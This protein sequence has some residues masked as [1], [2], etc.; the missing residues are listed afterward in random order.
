LNVLVAG[1]ITIDRI[2]LA[3]RQIT[4][5]G[6]PPCYAGIL[7]ARFG[8]EVTPLT[9]VGP[10][11]PNEQIVWL[12]RNGL[13]LRAIDQSSTKKTT[14]FK[15][16][17]KGDERS[18]HLVE[19]C[20]DLSLEQVPDRQFNASL[21]SPLAHEISTQV[22]EEVRKRSD[23]CFLDPQGFVRMFDG[24]GR[25]AI[26]SWH[27]EKVLGNVDALKMD[28]EEANALTGK[29]DGKAALVKLSKKVRKAVVTRG[30][31]SA[32]ILD[33]NK[34][35]QVE[36]PKVKVV[37]STGAGDIFAGALISCFLRSR[38]FLWS[39]CFGI[40]ASSL[41][42]N[43]I[44]LSKVDLPRSVDQQARKLYSSATTVETV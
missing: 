35:S 12:A 32:L 21:I 29:T 3:M 42:L 13:Q 10:D 43:S 7:C 39:C 23:F 36:V 30:G 15:L 44:A 6:G 27:D 20:E 18:L 17:N 9:K 24:S 1:F 8:F 26:D 25:V 14:R 33:G 28:L 31:D 37:D 40:A 22:F 16:V 4:S 11:F 19:R 41:S 34:I 2:D 5:I 38:D